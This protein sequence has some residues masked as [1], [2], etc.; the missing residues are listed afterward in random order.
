M[1][2]GWRRPRW[3]I[4]G[5]GRSGRTEAAEMAEV[6]AEAAEAEAVE[7]EGCIRGGSMYGRY[8]HASEE[9]G[10]IWSCRS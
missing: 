10:G 3:N 4:R 6:E 5:G 1:H 7:V 8:W 2:R 9:Y